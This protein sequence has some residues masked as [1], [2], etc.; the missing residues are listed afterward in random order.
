MFKLRQ[1]FIIFFLFV[2]GSIY[3]VDIFQAIINDDQVA[4][5]L[6]LDSKPNL[7]IRNQY[8]QTV[9]IQAVIYKKPEMIFAFLKAGVSKYAVDFH[10]KIA[11]DYAICMEREIVR[12]YQDEFVKNI[13]ITL[14]ILTSLYL[15]DQYVYEMSACLKDRNY[16]QYCPEF[17]PV[18]WK[19]LSE[20]PRLSSFLK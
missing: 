6:W 16:S 8:G 14:V 15:F 7:N 11:Y 3:S 17:E 18:K 19:K 9:L 5:Q 12:Y 2:T 1:F 10:G 20:C 13:V 4:V